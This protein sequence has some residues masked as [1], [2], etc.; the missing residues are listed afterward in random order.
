MKTK[1]EYLRFTFLTG[2]GLE[3]QSDG[4]TIEHYGL[5]P[6]SL[7]SFKIPKMSLIA[8]VEDDNQPIRFAVTTSNKMQKEISDKGQEKTDSFKII[9]VPDQND[10][11]MKT[12]IR[13]ALTTG[14]VRPMPGELS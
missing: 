10:A 1:K 14:R 5:I 2:N 4:K 7:S 11:L 13:I 8:V 6:E 3:H 12:V 9:F